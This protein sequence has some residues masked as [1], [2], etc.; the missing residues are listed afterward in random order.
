[1][2]DKRTSLTGAPLAKSGH[3]HPINEYSLMGQSRG[4]WRFEGFHRIWRKRERWRREGKGNSGRVLLAVAGGF[5]WETAL[6]RYEKFRQLVMTA[7]FSH[8]PSGNGRT[9]VG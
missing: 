5:P 9:G 7:F 6:E 1:M 2:A 4:N 8:S 3:A